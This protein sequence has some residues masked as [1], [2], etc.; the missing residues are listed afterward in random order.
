MRGN[1]GRYS[2]SHTG[3]EPITV[4]EKLRT[5]HVRRWH[6]VAMTREQTVAEHTH[7][8]V[9]LCEEILSLL[10]KDDWYD[11]LFV[12]TIRL[13]LCHD[14]HEFLLGDVPPPSKK[15][16][17]KVAGHDVFD[18]AAK[19]VDVHTEDLVHTLQRTAPL[20]VRVVKLADLIEAVNH[21]GTFGVGTHA[22][23]VWLGLQKAA[24]GAIA[25]LHEET[26]V[27][28]EDLHFLLDTLKEGRQ[29]A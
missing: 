3:N 29:F 13:A 4:Y 23:A 5:G 19:V 6:I 28:N 22:R 7:R 20:A 21:L 10:G 25:R 11:P 26:G 8:V 9:I 1:P 12:S 17:A 15:I 14:H 27:A 2:T 24:A 16:L 18:A